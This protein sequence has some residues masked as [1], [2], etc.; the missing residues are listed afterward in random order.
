MKSVK[1]TLLFAL[2]LIASAAK[3]W[4]QN[5]SIPEHDTF[6]IQSKLVGEVRTMNVWTPPSY[7]VS[8]ESLPVL[9][10][11]DGGLEEDFPH[12][13]NTLADL[14]SKN[15]IQ[16]IILVGIEN[17]KRKK[18]LTGPTQVEEDKEIAPEVG[19]SADFRAFINQELIPE[20]N[21]KY[22]TTVKK[23][24]I[25]E[26]L[27]GLFVMETFL[28]QP[29][30]FDFYIAFDPSLWWNNHHY[31]KNAAKYVANFPDK[32]ITLWFAT[33][34]ATGMH[35][36]AKNMVKVLEKIPSDQLS[37]KYSDESK[38]K[39]HTIFRATKEKAIMWTLRNALE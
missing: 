19:Q 21:K 6:T 17:T 20:I 3:A 38:E 33:S 4:Q 34:S 22:R 1:Y 26:S 25:G 24:I 27:A 31:D 15:K 28:L 12:I 36:A 11:P 37:W 14:I 5:D 18:D 16:P 2:V 7:K 9:Y 30:N 29:D 8:Q 10:M 13:A 35:K 32:K 39:H 23:G